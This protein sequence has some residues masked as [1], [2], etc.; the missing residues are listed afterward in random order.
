MRLFPAVR[1]TDGAGVRLRRYIGTNLLRDLDPFL[2]L[3]EIKS[4]DPEE[5]SGGFP[6]HPHRGFQTL[7]YM[8]RGRLKHRDSTGSE[9]TLEEGWVQWMNAGRGVIHSEMPVEG[10]GSLWCF[11]LWINNP[12]SLKMSEPFYRNF[13]VRILEASEERK[14]ID[15]VGDPLRKEG[16]YPVTCLH[17]YL[18]SGSHFSLDLPEENNTFLALSE[19]RLRAKAVE[20]PR[21][22]V[23]VTKGGVEVEALEDSNFLLC[24]AKPLGEP[25]VRWGPFVMNTWE[26]IDQA[27]KDLREGRF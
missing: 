3:D 10:T 2:L 27:V 9:D 16:F 13:P 25:I 23:A 6:D 17:V 8:V 21:G 15:L 26:E 12:R 20:V 19:G 7:T 18:R 5:F 4:G 11:Q 22:H 14:V 1:T 24:S